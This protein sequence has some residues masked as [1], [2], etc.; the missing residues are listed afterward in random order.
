[1]NS[2]TNFNQFSHKDQIVDI[3]MFSQLRVCHGRDDWWLILFCLSVF[4]ITIICLQLTINLQSSE[5]QFNKKSSTANSQ[6]RRL[7][8]K[9][10]LCGNIILRKLT[11]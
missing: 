3:E 2:Y 10:L 7:S 9:H 4:V 11:I 8:E 1:M 6:S 5:R